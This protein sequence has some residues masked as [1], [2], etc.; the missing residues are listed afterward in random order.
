MLNTLRENMLSLLPD[1][2][3]NAG[4]KQAHRP[5]C[6]YDQIFEPSLQKDTRTYISINWTPG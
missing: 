2:D 4:A 6:E 5:H 3:S 1:R